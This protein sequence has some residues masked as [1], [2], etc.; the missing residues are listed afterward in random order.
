MRENL[1][2]LIR[3]AIQ[4]WVRIRNQYGISVVFPQTSFQGGGGPAKLIVLVRDGGVES[5]MLA[6]LLRLTIL[7]LL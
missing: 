3:F 1:L 6:A 4:I 2:Q 7:R 5:K